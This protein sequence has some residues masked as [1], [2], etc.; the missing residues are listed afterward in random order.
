MLREVG[1]T[2]RLLLSG[3]STVCVNIVLSFIRPPPEGGVDG[4]NT[5]IFKKKKKAA[6]YLEI[7][8]W[9][10]R[11]F[12][13]PIWKGPCCLAVHPARARGSTSHSIC[14]LFIA[15]PTGR[16][17]KS[18]FRGNNFQFE[19]KKNKQLFDHLMHKTS[20]FVQTRLL[21]TNRGVL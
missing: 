7:H 10:T 14:T 15:L 12:Q 9:K 20:L 13:H 21:L 11:G 3:H 19:G 17:Q 2:A 5:L 1:G 8:K 6:N 4:L 18:C 16:H